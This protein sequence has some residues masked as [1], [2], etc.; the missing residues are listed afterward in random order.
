VARPARR[1]L[2]RLLVLV[3]AVVLVL[4]CDDEPPEE[5]VESARTACALMPEDITDS[6]VGELGP[7]L[8]LFEAYGQVEHL[9]SVDE[10]QVLLEQECPEA[11]QQFDDLAEQDAPQEPDADPEGAPEA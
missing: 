5:A 7:S 4:G 2:P 10:F 11:M 6:E 8:I 9:V 3:G 1:T